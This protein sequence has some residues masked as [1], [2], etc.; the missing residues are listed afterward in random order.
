MNENSYYMSIRSTSLAHYIGKA[1]ILPSRFYKKRPTDIQAIESDYII[2]A[3]D[4]FLNNSNCSIEIILNEQEREDLEQKNNNLFFYKIPI[5]LSRIKKIFFPNEDEKIL[6]VSDINRGT[7]FISEKIVEVVNEKNVSVEIEIDNYKYNEELENKI[8]TYNNILGGLAFVRHTQDGQYS[9]NYFS[10]LSHFNKLIEKDYKKNNFKITNKYDGA[11]TGIDSNNIRFW[12]ELY[13]LLYEDI[14]E[15]DVSTFSQKEGI[16]I[17]KLNGVLNYETIKDSSITYKL[18]I[19]STYGEDSTKRKKT[20]DLIS[21][22]KN[23]QISKDKQEGI[24]LI[25]GIN[26][27]YSTFRNQYDKKIV[28]FKMDSLLDYYTIESV[29]QYVINDRKDNGKFEYIDNIGIEK[30]IILNKEYEIYTILDE[31]IITKEKTIIAKFK[32]LMTSIELDNYIDNLFEKIKNLMSEK[33]ELVNRN[34]RLSQQ[35]NNKLKN[36]EDKYKNETKL[37]EKLRENE[38]KLIKQFDSKNIEIQ[39]LTTSKNQLSEQLNNKQR[40]LENQSNELKN[41]EDKYNNETKFVEELKKNK[42]ELRKQLDSKNIEIKNLTTSKNQLSEQLNNIQD[43][44]NNETKFVEEL[45]KN[46]AELKKQ[47]DSKNIEMQDLTNSKIQLSEQLNNKQKEFENKSNDIQKKY[48]IEI[49]NNQE[50]KNIN[51]QL[52]KQLEEKVE[53]KDN[54]LKI[55]DEEKEK[56]SIEEFLELYDKNTTELKKIAKGKGIKSTKKRELIKYILCHKN[57]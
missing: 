16:S 6:N 26:N 34:M 39:N 11:F 30:E 43:K 28:K 2:L 21:D 1:L 5:P 27:G 29:F 33:K 20:N 13:P 56:I 57:K 46:E 38:A 44:Y 51:A 9:E 53:P 4:K 54:N 40:E 22:C 15:Q 52:S 7:G 47:L 25:Y 14:T 3:K 45:R 18:A 50:L 49:Q 48:N 8:E 35:L 36:I 32:E 41:I 42:L 55:F 12:E 19:L 37:V 10:I 24:S 23:E 17:N 31:T